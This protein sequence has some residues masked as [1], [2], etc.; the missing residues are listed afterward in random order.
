LND[1]P[2]DKFAC[3]KCFA[4][5][6]LFYEFMTDVKEKQHINLFPIKREPKELHELYEEGCIVIFSNT[7]EN[8]E[9]RTARMSTGGKRRRIKRIR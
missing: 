8:L 2:E 1:F 3:L 4:H 5:F 9:K 6:K 7:E